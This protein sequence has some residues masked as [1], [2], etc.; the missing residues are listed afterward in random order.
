LAPA[1]E[2]SGPL[3]L[4]LLLLPSLHVALGEFDDSERGANM[5]HMQFLRE[6]KAFL[7]SEMGVMRK[8]MQ[9]SA[10]EEE[11]LAI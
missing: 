10:Q 2:Y 8:E 6:Q 9:L 3:P 1:P 5:N 7:E 4:P 11:I